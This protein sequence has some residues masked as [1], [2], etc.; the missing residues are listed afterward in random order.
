V[1][2]LLIT[3]GEQN[4]IFWRRK[5]WKMETIEIRLNRPKKRL[6]NRIYLYD[7]QRTYHYYVNR[8]MLA[9]SYSES[10]CPVCKA[11]EEAKNN[12]RNN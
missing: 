1:A 3:D 9:K 7:F 12:G 10:V 4:N 11:E 5:G 6:N 8:D 2:Y